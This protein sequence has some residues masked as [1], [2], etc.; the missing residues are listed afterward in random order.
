MFARLNQKILNKNLNSKFLV[1]VSEA[2]DEIVIALNDRVHIS[3]NTVGTLD[4]D[5]LD[6]LFL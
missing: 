4:I 6:K 2:I 1:K 5:K 3:T